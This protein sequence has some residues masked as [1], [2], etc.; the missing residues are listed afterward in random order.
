MPSLSVWQHSREIC[1]CS[2]L[3]HAEEISSI[4]GAGAIVRVHPDGYDREG[5]IMWF[6]GRIL[7]RLGMTL[8]ALRVEDARNERRSSDRSPYA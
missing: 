1:R 3:I 8:F 5:W 7:N 6:E 2:S 4:C